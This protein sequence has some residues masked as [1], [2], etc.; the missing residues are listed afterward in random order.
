[1]KLPFQAPPVIRNAYSRQGRPAQ[2][3]RTERKLAPIVRG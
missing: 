3:R 1:M 2:G